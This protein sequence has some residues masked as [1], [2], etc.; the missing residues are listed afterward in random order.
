LEV[1]NKKQRG[2]IQSFYEENSILKDELS[3]QYFNNE[4]GIKERVMFEVKL[5]KLHSLNRTFRDSAVIFRDEKESK[6]AE[7]KELSI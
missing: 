1:L 3:H 4:K 6:L 5:N 7:L 2:E